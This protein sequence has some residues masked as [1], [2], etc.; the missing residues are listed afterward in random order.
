MPP[1]GRGR[2]ALVARPPLRPVPLPSRGFCLDRGRSLLFPEAL[3]FVPVSRLGTWTRRSLDAEGRAGA[4]SCSAN[5]SPASRPRHSLLIRRKDH[6]EPCARTASRELAR[7]LALENG[8]C[9]RKGGLSVALLLPGELARR[10]AWPGREGQALG[11]PSGRGVASGGLPRLRRG[12]RGRPR[13]AA[14]YV[15]FSSFPSAQS[16]LWGGANKKLAG[17]D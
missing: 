11:R 7:A 3:E 14:R 5:R 12:P 17:V 4:W 9:S 6:G 13:S 8:S 1:E 10:Y 2:G 15:R 16:L